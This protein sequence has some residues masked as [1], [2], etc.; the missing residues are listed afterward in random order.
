M[1]MLKRLFRI[2]ELDRAIRELQSMS[3][4]ELLDL[5]I[6][7]HNIRERLLGQE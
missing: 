5:G 2:S 7:R 3:D 6:S 1:N 4:R